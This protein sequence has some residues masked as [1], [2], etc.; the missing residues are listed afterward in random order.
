MLTIE[1]KKHLVSSNKYVKKTKLILTTWLIICIYKLLDK[2]NLKKGYTLP[3][4]INEFTGTFISI[5]QYSF[6]S[7]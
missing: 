5:V 3:K 7:V 2:R 4:I 6:F 1:Y